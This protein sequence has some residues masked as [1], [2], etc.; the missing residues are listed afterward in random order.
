M[1]ARGNEEKRTYNTR[2]ILIP[3][4]KRQQAKLLHPLVRRGFP[5]RRPPFLFV[6][7]QNCAW[8]KTVYGTTRS[9]TL[10]NPSSLRRAAPPPL[11]ELASK[12]NL[13]VDVR[14]LLLQPREVVS[15]PA[16][17]DERTV[18]T[19]EIW[20]MFGKQPR[21]APPNRKSLLPLGVGRIFARY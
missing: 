20:K 19:R 15:Q 8:S 6:T 2:M 17:P 16:F 11:H 21:G 3:R 1:K 10:S 7:H 12:L 14:L 18:R 9:V 5:K 4:P 13:L